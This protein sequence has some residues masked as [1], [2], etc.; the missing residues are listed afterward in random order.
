MISN[1]DLILGALAS[2]SEEAL[3]FPKIVVPLALAYLKGYRCEAETV[4]ASG[5]SGKVSKV[6]ICGMPYVM[7]TIHP[8]HLENVTEAMI[9]G[10][11]L[12][13]SVASR[14]LVEIVGIGTNHEVFM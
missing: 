1:L 9:R 4:I 10:A 14:H 7:K 11:T 8:Q 6:T 13:H 12:C 2:S 5:A 3:K